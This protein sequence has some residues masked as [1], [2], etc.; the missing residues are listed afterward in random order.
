MS[1]SNSEVCI[2]R[3]LLIGCG[4]IL[5]F[6]K[7]VVYMFA[8]GSVIRK[9]IIVS[10]DLQIEV[11]ARWYFAATTP[12]DGIS[13]VTVRISDRGKIRRL[14]A[15][16]SFSDAPIQIHRYDPKRAR[17]D[18]ELEAR[19]ALREYFHFL[20]LALRRKTMSLLEESLLH[21]RVYRGMQDGDS[22]Q[23]LTGL[24]FVGEW[25]QIVRI[26]YSLIHSHIALIR[27]TDYEEFLRIVAEKLERFVDEESDTF[28]LRAIAKKPI[29]EVVLM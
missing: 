7:E 14:Q 6:F 13:R 27:P 28:D 3:A 23:L 22:W 21:F 16:W 24:E 4:R 9:T 26:S 18:A 29:A 8:K 10:D 15:I 19:W 20:S 25:A 12:P 11:S 5:F 2:A 1:G 17:Q